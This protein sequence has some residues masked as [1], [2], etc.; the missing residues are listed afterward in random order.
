MHDKNGQSILAFLTDRCKALVQERT[1][2]AHKALYAIPSTADMPECIRRM[3]YIREALPRFERLR[4]GI[5]LARL[6]GQDLNVVLQAV[7]QDVES[8]RKTFIQVSNEAENLS[9]SLAA[10]AAAVLLHIQVELQA[11]STQESPAPATE[12]VA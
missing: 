8:A 10:C 9:T 11:F 12:V 3:T 1:E 6:N 7:L 5:H 4:D 2:L